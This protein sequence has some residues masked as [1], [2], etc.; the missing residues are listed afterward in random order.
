M[1]IKVNDMYR[2]PESDPTFYAKILGQEQQFYKARNKIAEKYNLEEIQKRLKN[3]K[4]EQSERLRLEQELSDKI[5]II[6]KD[7]LQVTLTW[8]KNE[9]KKASNY[10]KILINENKL[11]KISAQKEAARFELEMIKNNSALSEDEKKKQI[12]KQRKSMRALSKEQTSLNNMNAQLSLL[13]LNSFNDAKKKGITELAIWALKQ[14]KNA[15]KAAIA[16]TKDQ[17]KKDI[18]NYKKTVEKRKKLEKELARKKA[19]GK[20]TSDVEAKLKD[21]SKLETDARKKAD[22]SAANYMKTQL[23]DAVAQFSSA[24]TDFAID[25]Q[26]KADS[27]MSSYQSR[28]N[29]SLQGSTT[30]FSDILDTV[31]KNLAISPVV[32]MEKVIDNIKEASDKG[33]AYNIEQRAFLNTVSDKI[34]HTFDAFDSNLTRLIRLQQADTTAARLGLEANLTKLFNSTFNDSSYLSDVYDSVSRAIIDANSQLNKNESA[35]FEYTV[36]KWLGSLYSLGL[37]GGTITQIAQGINYLA[38]GDVTSLANNTSLQTLLAMSA[39]NAGLDYA[40]IML[41]GLD[42]STTNKLLQSMVLYLKDIAE[43]SDNQVV[44]GAYGNILNMSLSDMTAFSNMSTS[45]ISRISGTNMT[46]NALVAETQSQLFQT[47]LRQSMTET[48]NNVLQNATYGMGIDM[49]QNPATWAMSKM[50]DFMNSSG[51]DIN[52][53]FISAAG[54]GVDLNASVN[55]LLRLGLGLSGAMS[56]VGNVL[57]ALGTGTGTGLSLGDWGGT[58]YNQRGTGFGGLLGT[59]LGATSSSTY[60]NNSSSSDMSTDAI[61]TATDDAENTKKITNKNAQPDDHTLDDFWN[62]TVGEGASDYFK[63][64]DDILRWAYDSSV[65]SIRVFDKTGLTYMATVFGTEPLYMNGMLKT[66]D[67]GIQDVKN[68]N[69][70]RVTDTGLSNI[71]RMS[72]DSTNALRTII[73]NNSITTRIANASDIGN[74]IKQNSPTQMSL[75]PGTTVSISK[76]SLVAAIVEALGGNENNI[77]LKQFVDNSI[78]GNTGAPPLMRVSNEGT[79]ELDVRVTNAV[80]FSQ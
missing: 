69:S 44:K 64:Q 35:A 22:I 40:K 33:I 28:I 46:Y 51:I 32:Q 72:F 5:K 66:V 74:A 68:G 43:N 11:K 26:K 19:A 56:L 18:V 16:A 17:N 34:A 24:F 47:L 9:F 31:Q 45:D 77:K 30:N 12:Q 55:Q 71:G 80:A 6:E 61:A 20:D 62:A 50:L 27:M 48:M 67:F 49:A 60:I 59:L 37:S 52:I 7:A 36:Q 23:I 8:Q 75:Q 63:V 39:S 38:T 65:E 3:R 58:E 13:Q 76:A 57:G 53:P 54:F 41:E 73:T 29:A 15:R 1:A 10:E 2:T 42:S 78:R 25:A 21:A 70:L 79:R 14:D 4:L